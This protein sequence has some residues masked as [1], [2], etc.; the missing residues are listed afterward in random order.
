MKRKVILASL[1]LMCLIGSISISSAVQITK[2]GTG[3]DPA[4][5]G[6][7]VTWS[8]TSGS[9]HVYDLSLKRYTNKFF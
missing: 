3:H 2:I 1:S 8:D 9:I 5:Y 6:N 4:I 7:N